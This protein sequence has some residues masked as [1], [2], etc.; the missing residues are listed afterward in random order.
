MSEKIFIIPPHRTRYL[1]EISE[2]NRNYDH[3]SEQQ[4]SIADKLYAL[5]S[6]IRILEESESKNQDDASLN[7][8]KSSFDRIKL[9]LNPHNWEMTSDLG[10]TNGCCIRMPN[11]NSMVRDKEIKLLHIPKVYL[12]K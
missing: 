4:S 9:D 11:T 12:I 7:M 3:W 1:S 10:R 8:L 2:N 5:D 6:S